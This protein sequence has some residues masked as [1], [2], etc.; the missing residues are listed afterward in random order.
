MEDGLLLVRPVLGTAGVPRVRS[1]V[2]VQ[3]PLLRK[4]RLTSERAK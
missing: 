4:A 2:Q 1:Q 3:R